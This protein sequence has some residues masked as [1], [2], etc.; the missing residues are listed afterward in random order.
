MLEK[1]NAITRHYEQLGEDLVRS[2]QTINARPRSTRNGRTWRRSWPDPGS[3]RAPCRAW[4]KLASF[5]HPIVRPTR[6]SA[7]SPRPMCFS[8]AED[9]GAG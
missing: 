6:N 5:S 2:A 7:R 8:D 1:L 3:I 9:R 4:K